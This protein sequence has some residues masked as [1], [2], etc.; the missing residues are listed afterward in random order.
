MK[1]T[2][3]FGAFVAIFV[4]GSCSR[5]KECN[6]TVKETGYDSLFNQWYIRSYDTTQTIVVGTC[7]DLNSYSTGS[8][9]TEDYGPNYNWTRV[10]ECVEQQSDHGGGNNNNNNDDGGGSNHG[11]NGNL[12]FYFSSTGTNI[13]YPAGSSTVYF[14]SNTDWS[15][16]LDKSHFGA[17]ASVSPT[18]GKGR[19]SV[20]ISYGEESN[21]YDC[22]DYL[23]A[24]FKFV[25]R[26]NSDGSKHYDTKTYTITRKYHRTTP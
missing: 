20:V 7:E 2:L 13:D 4:F 6:C 23:Y 14:E 12:Y 15:V 9:Q 19:G 11:G 1:K 26:I 18:S 5:S 8:T 22:D 25:D 21:H 24:N 16:T 10:V 17:S 3:I